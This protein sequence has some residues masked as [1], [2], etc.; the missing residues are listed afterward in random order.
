MSSAFITFE[1]IEGA[2]KSTQIQHLQRFLEGQG[3][4]VIVTREPGGSENAEKIRALLVAGGTDDW[5]AVSECLLVNAARADHLRRL[6]RPALVAGKT[7]LCDRFMDS[8]RAYQ[9]AAGGLDMAHLS[10]ME[11][12][13]VGKTRP[14]LTLIFDLD[15]ETGL[16]RAGKRGGDDRFERKGSAYHEAVRQGF[17][18]IAAAEPER[19]AVIDA[20]TSQDDVAAAVR[21]ALQSRG[22]SG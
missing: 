19:C 6:I 10:A 12:A 17:L 1:G 15:V 8:T 2:G 14:D 21:Q 4:E 13:V 18:E 22:L 5:E 9:G 16:S 20:G 3:R 11:A 7:V